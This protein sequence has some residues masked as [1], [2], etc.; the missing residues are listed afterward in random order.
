MTS[1]P[2]HPDHYNDIR[3]VIMRE[4][5][6]S[7]VDNAFLSCH[8]LESVTIP[9][10][11]TSIGAFAFNDRTALSSV[12][13]PG[14][15]TRIGKSAFKENNLLTTIL[16]MGTKDQFASVNTGSDLFDTSSVER[17]IIYLGETSQLV[18]VYTETIPDNGGTV[19]LS[20]P[21][22]NTNSTDVFT[23]DTDGT[24]RVT[25][26]ANP[27][28]GYVFS[29]WLDRDGSPI[30][31]DGTQMPV[32]PEYSFAAA[33]DVTVTAVFEKTYTIAADPEMTNGTVTTDKN[34]ARA[35]DAIILTPVP[36]GGYGLKTLTCTTA[37]GE[38]ITITPFESAYSIIMPADDVIV[39]AAFIP[40][41]DIPEFTVE[42]GPG[43][44]AFVQEKFSGIE[45]SSVSGTQLILTLPHASTISDARVMFDNAAGSLLGET[46]NGEY[47]LGTLA[48]NP[49]GSYAS[50]AAVNAEA[51]QYD[52]QPIPVGGITFYAQWAVPVGDITV[53]VVP[54][55]VGTQVTTTSPQGITRTVPPVSAR[56]VS[57]N[58]EFDASSPANWVT[59][60]NSSAAWTGTMA[61]GAEYYASFYVDAKYGYFFPFSVNETTEPITYT[62]LDGASVT[63]A[64]DS[65]AVV[66]LTGNN[67]VKIWAKVIVTK[68]AQ[69]ISA[70]DVNAICGDTGAKIAA[71]DRRRRRNQLR[72]KERQRGVHRSE[73]VHRRADDQGSAG[74]L[75][76]LCP[77]HGG[78]DR[79]LRR[80]NQ[81]SDGHDLPQA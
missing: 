27:A 19:S 81:R 65:G 72:G 73:R 7:I 79:R 31:D 2:W 71:K 30:M 13:I 14:S 76:S 41:P 43:H 18:R 8:A 77:R 29:R 16:Y 33:G 20:G 68:A 80:S 46:D 38:A 54:P 78:G 28:S 22:A 21:A 49:A 6:T 45:N 3:K 50:Q 36:D 75:Q 39:S 35:G 66:S 56:V 63:V 51:S 44:E 47:F 37:G 59:G 24:A 11:V 32:G 4:G 26:S 42:F 62:L 23:K 5:V 12:T 25:A 1:H 10:G 69:T 55:A 64:N 60:Y 34:P 15:V 48:Q 70:D 40:L 17:R 57:G 74:E 53:E 52:S 61:E 9:N 58:A 67:S